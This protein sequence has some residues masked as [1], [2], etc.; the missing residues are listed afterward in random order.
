MSIID[1]T[2]LFVKD[3]LQN[4]EGGHDWFHIE[5]VYKN[6][7]S[8]AET[9]TCDLTVVKLGAL[10]HDIAD[11]KFHDGDEEIGPQ[12]ARNYLESQ[13]VSIE[14][15]FSDGKVADADIEKKAKDLEEI[16][17]KIE[18]KE[19][20]DCNAYR[21]IIYLGYL[22][23]GFSQEAASAASYEF[24]FGCLSNTVPKELTLE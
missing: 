14:Q 19:A 5:R 10:L 20:L 12:K 4:A 9:E 1:K 23:S 11:S 17:Q 6:A 7:I 13:K 16:I 8:I 2:I 24:Y 18:T 21:V 22:G 3:K 15:L